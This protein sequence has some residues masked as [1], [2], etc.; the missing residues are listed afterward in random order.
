MGL[1]SVNKLTVDVQLEHVQDMVPSLLLFFFWICNVRISC[2]C[3]IPQK[4]QIEQIHHFDCFVLDKSTKEEIKN[5]APLQR[6]FI[7]LGK[8][9]I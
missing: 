1:Y 2:P 3:N 4:W 5:P 7:Y 6:N 8:I 9:F